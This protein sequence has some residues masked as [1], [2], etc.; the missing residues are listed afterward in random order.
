[1]PGFQY[2]NNQ[3]IDPSISEATDKEIVSFISSCRS[4]SDQFRNKFALLTGSYVK[5]SEKCENLYNGVLYTEHQK[6]TY[7][8]KPD[9]YA[10]YVD[11]DTELMR[12]FPAKAFVKQVDKGD[13]GVTA[14]P[15]VAM[16]RLMEHCDKINRTDEKDDDAIQIR[17][18]QGNAFYKFQPFEV[19]GVLWPGT[20]VVK[21]HEVFFSPGSVDVQDSVYFGWRRPVPTVQIQQQYSELAEK[22]QP[23]VEISDEK[24]GTTSS[25]DKTIFNAIGT[26]VSAAFGKLSGGA[27]ISSKQTWLTEFYYKDPEMVVLST[28]EEVDAWMIENTAVVFEQ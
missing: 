6:K 27:S 28:P 24:S 22:I 9:D 2:T 15:A 7:E 8:C 19:D 18:I 14:L 17:G 23:D 20:E 21:P 25:G 12:Q 4:E 11:L 3:T 10:Y 13:A 26:G 1:M 5:D 16:T